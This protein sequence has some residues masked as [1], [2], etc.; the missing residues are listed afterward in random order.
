MLTPSDPVSDP[1]VYLAAERTFLA[2][3]RTSISLMGFGF[4]IARLALWLRAHALD[5]PQ[6]AQSKLAFATALGSGMVGV[7]VFVSVFAA[8]GHRNY[9]RSLQQGVANPPLR[10]GTS[11]ALAG[12]LAFVGVAIALHILTL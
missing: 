1:R 11:I 8:V 9:I 7:G 3:I 10:M 6:R 4:V 12:I 5:E 2:W